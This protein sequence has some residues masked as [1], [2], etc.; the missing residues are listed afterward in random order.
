METTW[1]PHWAAGPTP[2]G[3]T[4]ACPDTDQRLRQQLAEVFQSSLDGK[5]GGSSPDR[6]GERWEPEAGAAGCWLPP[7]SSR[8]RM[9]RAEQDPSPAGRESSGLCSQESAEPPRAPPAGL[10]PGAS[11]PA[12]S[13]SVVSA[14]V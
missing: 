3:S 4:R 7:H 13:A 12:Q 5:G 10:R 14:A 1:G 9:L 6:P 2:S 11:R 8:F